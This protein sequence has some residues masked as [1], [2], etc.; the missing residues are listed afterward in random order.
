PLAYATLF[1]RT[2]RVQGHRIRRLGGLPPARGRGEGTR[3]GRGTRAREDRD[4][5]SHARRGAG[6][7]DRGGERRLIS[8]RR[9]GGSVSFS[10]RLAPTP[11]QTSHSDPKR[12]T[13]RPRTR[14][15]VFGVVDSVT[16]D[17]EALIVIDITDS[18]EKT[19]RGY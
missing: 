9:P 10:I 19:D 12:S 7:P 17:D 1:R 14:K 16:S 3:R 13:I 5:G 15:A 18:Q 6:S 8:P 11:P 4:P 2:A